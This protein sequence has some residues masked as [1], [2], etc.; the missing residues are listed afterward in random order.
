MVGTEYELTSYNYLVLIKLIIRA[1]DTKNGWPF[2][3]L[4]SIVTIV[5]EA[6]DNKLGWQQSALLT[7]AVHR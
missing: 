5:S 1:G 3:V 2:D 7:C 6:A 4:L